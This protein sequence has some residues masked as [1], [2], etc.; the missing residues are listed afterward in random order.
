VQQT[1]NTS[2]STLRIENIEALMPMRFGVLERVAIFYTTSVGT[3][4]DWSTT[5]RL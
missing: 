1:A 2:R 3:L 5:Q 4:Y